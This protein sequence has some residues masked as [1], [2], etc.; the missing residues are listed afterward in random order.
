VRQRPWL[1]VAPAMLRQWSGSG[2]EVPRRS[3]RLDPG[4]AINLRKQWLR[5]D[6]RRMKLGHAYVRAALDDPELRSVYDAEARARG[7]RVCDL[8]MSDFLTDPVIV[9]INTDKYQGRAG[10][11]VIIIGGPGGSPLRGEAK[12]KKKCM[13][14]VKL[15]QCSTAELIWIAH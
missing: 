3:V 6:Q 11:S 13:A 2:R 4:S 14:K 7:M 9:A 10:D 5:S 8:V 15:A 1:G 12:R